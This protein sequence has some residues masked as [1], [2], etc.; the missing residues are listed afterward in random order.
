MLIMRAR[1]IGFALTRESC[2][3]GTPTHGRR[4]ASRDP[5]LFPARLARSRT[6]PGSH[7]GPSTHRVH[8][9]RSNAGRSQEGARSSHARALLELRKKSTHRPRDQPTTP[10]SAISQTGRLPGRLPS[11]AVRNRSV[12][13]VLAEKTVGFF[14]LKNY[15]HKV[16]RQRCTLRKGQLKSI[17]SQETIHTTES[18]TS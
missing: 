14:S 7:I 15:M 13:V 12:H 6:H 17:H 1:L 8:A 5:N 9:R 4:L 11:G 3:H 16:L 10:F 18:R 2:F